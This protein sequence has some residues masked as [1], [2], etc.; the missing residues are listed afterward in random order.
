VLNNQSNL[1][2]ENPWV[3]QTKIDL[4]KQIN[5]WKML[6]F[7]YK[8]ILGIETKYDCTGKKIKNLPD[9]SYVNIL[10]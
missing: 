2:L 3:K 9:M 7:L 10:W 1:D 5:I 6:R 8:L 4:N